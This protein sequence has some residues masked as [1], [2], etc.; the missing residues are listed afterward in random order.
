MSND[1]FLILDLADRPGRIGILESGDSIIWH[2]LADDL[3]SRKIVQAVH[4]L[5]RERKMTLKQ[6]SAFVTVTGGSSFTG[7][8]LGA[9]V[10]NAF[11]WAF[12]R[13]AVG[14]KNVSSARLIQARYKSAKPN[15][16]IE[17]T[18]PSHPI[19]KTNPR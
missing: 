18:Y 14:M 11:A 16:T 4:A 5:L 10:G 12:G 1:T 13:P 2:P 9:S 6:M 3:R 8:R 19:L 17:I 7:M 15:A